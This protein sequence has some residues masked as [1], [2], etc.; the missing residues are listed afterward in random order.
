[1]VEGEAV[2]LGI[3]VVVEV[4]IEVVTEGNITILSIRYKPE[5]KLIY[6]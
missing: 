1:M 3:E 5:I 4:V 6:I 2:A